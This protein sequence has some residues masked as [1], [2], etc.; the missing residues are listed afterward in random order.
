MILLDPDLEP[1]AAPRSSAVKQTAT[2]MSRGLRVPSVRVLARFLNEAKAAARLRGQVTVLLTTDNA[3]RNLNRR[4]RRKNKPTD[5]L[6]FPADA[7]APGAER[8][9]G[10]L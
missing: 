2:A 5:V 10:D 1:D 9:A 8:I 6:S 7:T 4:F 3:I